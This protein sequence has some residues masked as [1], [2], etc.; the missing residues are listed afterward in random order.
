MDVAKLWRSRRWRLLLNLIDH[1]PAH[2]FYVEAQLDDEDLAERILSSGEPTAAAGPRLS[3]WDPVVRELTVITDRLSELTA[4]VVQGLG[5]KARPDYR[6]RPAT[7]LD[8]VRDR[9]VR[10]KHRELVR[11]LTPPT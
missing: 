3:E 10:D 11:R 2:S 6:P 7:A 5:G 8:A 1:L 9:R 4:V